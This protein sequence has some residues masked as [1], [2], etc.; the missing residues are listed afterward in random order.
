M[1]VMPMFPLGT[2]L[3]PGGVLPLHVFEERYRQMVRDLLEGDEPSEFGVVMIARGRE[4]GGG[5]VRHDVGTLARVVDMHALPDGRYALVAVGAERLR[6]NAWLPDDPYPLADIDLW[7]DDDLGEIDLIA[8]TS[9]IDLLHE[10]VRLLNDEVRALGEMTPPPDTEIADDPHV[11]IYHLG[12]LAPLGPADRQRMLESA[13]LAERL[14]VFS[15][16]L[17]DAA[18]VVRFRSA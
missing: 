12:S 7:P 1:G 6:V 16:A 3:L 2:A 14:D 4:V 5:E 18:A 17:D 13:T 8:A 9:A 10:R 15:A 11:A